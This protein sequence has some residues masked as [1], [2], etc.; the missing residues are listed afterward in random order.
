MAPQSRGWVV[1]TQCKL[2]SRLFVLEHN[3]WQVGP[4]NQVG[5]GPVSVSLIGVFQRFNI[6]SK[7]C[8]QFI[9]FHVRPAGR[10]N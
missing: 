3:A 6:L 2:D 4:V 8:H 1:A 7:K 9:R 5:S 10:W